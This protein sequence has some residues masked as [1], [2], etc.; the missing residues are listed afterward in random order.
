MPYKSQA[1]S[2]S[3]RE[4]RPIRPK[5]R[6][7][8]E[9]TLPESRQSSHGFLRKQT[10][11]KDGSH[12]ETSHEQPYFT[13]KRGDRDILSYGRPDRYSVPNYSRIGHGKILG[14][15]KADK[16]NYNLSN[17]QAIVIHDPSFHDYA[18]PRSL[19]TNAP[20]EEELRIVPTLVEDKT[21]R[22]ENHYIPLLPSNKNVYSATSDLEDGHVNVEYEPIVGLRVS[23]KEVFEEL[24]SNSNPIHNKFEKITAIDSTAQ[25]RE[26]NAHLSRKVKAEPCNLGAWIELAEHQ[27]D[28]A[29]LSKE[30]AKLRLTDN[31]QRTLAEIRLSIYENALRVIGNDRKKIVCLLERIMTEGSKI[32]DT[33]TIL[34]RWQKYL[35]LHPAAIGL[36]KLYLNFVQSSFS[37]FRLEHFKSIFVKCLKTL[38]S[39]EVSENIKNFR[40]YVILRFSV[41][42][43]DAGYVELA[44]A[45]WQALLEFHI[46]KPTESDNLN[47]TKTVASS[48]V[49]LFE[50]F[51]ESEVPRIG[52][53]GALGWKT[54]IQSKGD[55]PNPVV[56]SLTK[57]IDEQDC[58]LSF[59]RDELLLSEEDE[60]PG[61]SLDDIGDN[62]PYH[63]ILF[64]DICD[65]VNLSPADIPAFAWI[66]AFLCFCT[67]PPLQCSDK[68]QDL[69]VWWQDT[70]LRTDWKRHVGG[71]SSI[72]TFSTRTTTATLLSPSLLLGG[73]MVPVTWITNALASL[74]SAI[75]EN[76]IIAQYYLAFVYQ[77]YPEK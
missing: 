14:L 42:A 57:S 28:L 52:E 65:F 71:A 51:W 37:L 77:N 41:L 11:Y 23:Q 2:K 16:I 67:L 20:E 58:F 56:S 70:F 7:R 73:Q 4:A 22:S 74:S 43:R 24:A 13:D 30:P 19:L 5:D 54:Y 32:W 29:K 34:S 8:S 63:V 21:W 25:I 38:A 50:E 39:A 75:S 6:H 26:R 33:K 59:A 66:Q 48:N 35:D 53:S 9:S 18:H 44:I 40:L 49:D 47:Q 27:E 69:D 64:S 31:E 68:T 61:R 60:L 12:F 76:G 15:G 36:W 17:D 72:P 1:S 62:D 10:Q 46:F 55:P 45:I 3:N